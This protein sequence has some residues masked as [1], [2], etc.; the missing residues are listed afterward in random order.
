[1]GASTAWYVIR[2]PGLLKP[3]R[4]GTSPGPQLL[5]NDTCIGTKLLAD[6]S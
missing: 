3:S 6:T 1:M 4:T 2:G 5:G